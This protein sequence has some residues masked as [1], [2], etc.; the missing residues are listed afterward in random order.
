M[1]LLKAKATRTRVS[2]VIY[3]ALNALLPLAIFFLARLDPPYLA[4]L[5]VFLSKWRILALRPRFWWTNIKANM[6]DITVGVSVVG[7]LYLSA[8]MLALQILIAVGYAV[9]LLAIKPRSGAHGIMLQAGIAQF[10]GLVTLMHF[11]TTFPEIFILLGAWAVS[12]ISAR[13]VISNYEEPY[14]EVLASIW[15]LVVAELTWLTYRWTAVYSLGLPIKIPQIAL[16]MLVIGYCAARMYHLSKHDRLTE[17]TLKSNV[18]FGA[19]LL[20]IIIL[21]S[22]WNA[23]V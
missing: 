15:G 14:T 9:W 4:L 5:L 1:E 11:S 23:K 3:V 16:M 20:A 6:V 2:E 8:S 7:M 19:V 21:F 17:S 22:P 13:H 10:L 18:I 12:Y